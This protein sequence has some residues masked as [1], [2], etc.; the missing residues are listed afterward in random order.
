MADTTTIGNVQLQV[1]DEAESLGFDDTVISA[2]LDSG[3][4]ET[5]TILAVWRGI[6]AKTAAI[7]DVAESGSSRTTKL[8]DRAAQMITI[9]QARSDAEDVAA[10]TG[11]RQRF[12]S[13]SIVRP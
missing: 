6:A 2:M 12:A 13:H 5:K 11:P 4:T 3:L 8:F 10:S 7:E 1:A 9:W